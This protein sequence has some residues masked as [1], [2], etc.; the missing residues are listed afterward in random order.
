MEIIKNNTDFLRLFVRNRAAVIGL[1]LLIVIILLAILAPLIYPDN[2]SQEN[3]GEIKK[4][5]RE[6]GIQNSK[7]YTF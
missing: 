5:F 7:N 1:L 2:P 3:K 4:L 6:N